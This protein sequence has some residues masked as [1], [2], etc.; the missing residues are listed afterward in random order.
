MVA[1]IGK[2]CT[3]KLQILITKITITSLILSMPLTT[4]VWIKLLP[5]LNWSTHLWI[6]LSKLQ[7]LKLA[8]INQVSKEIFKKNRIRHKKDQSINSCFLLKGKSRADLWQLTGSSWEIFG[9]S[10]IHAIV[11]SVSWI[12][13]FL[14]RWFFNWFYW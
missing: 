11:I 8:C 14:P 12:V 5:N 4:K 6:G 13:E 1:W 10:K 9:T 3:L 7:A 2:E